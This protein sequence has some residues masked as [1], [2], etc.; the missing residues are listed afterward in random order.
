MSYE[1]L[2]ACEVSGVNGVST[3]QSVAC[4]HGDLR[5]EELHSELKK[6]FPSSFLHEHDYAPFIFYLT[7]HFLSHFSTDQ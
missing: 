4:C 3:L 7:G 5:S 2:S 6:G 1:R